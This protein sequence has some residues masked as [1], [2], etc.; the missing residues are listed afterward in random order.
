MATA[1]PSGRAAWAI[2]ESGSAKDGGAAAMKTGRDV[3]RGNRRHE[4]RVVSERVRAKRL[5]DVR[6]QIDPHK[7]QWTRRTP[8]AQRENPLSTLCPLWWQ[9]RWADFTAYK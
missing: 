9:R 2:S 3:R 7:T 4:C 6:I 1:T 8:R 5:A